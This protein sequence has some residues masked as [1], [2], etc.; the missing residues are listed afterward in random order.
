MDLLVDCAL[1]GSTADREGGLHLARP[2]RMWRTW[3]RLNFD[4]ARS[5]RMRRGKF[6]RRQVAAGRTGCNIPD[7]R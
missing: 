2:K 7:E 4:L 5:R 3:R 6:R 1:R